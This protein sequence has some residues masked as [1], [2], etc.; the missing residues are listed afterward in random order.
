M[1]KTIKIKKGLNI[2]LLGGSE[3]IMKT[4]QRASFY[5]IKPTD[6]H[7][8]IP[9]MI[10]NEGEKVHA[11]S[12]LFFDKHNEN[13]KFTS[14]VSGVFQEVVRGAK[15]RILEVVVKPDESDTYIDYGA[16]KPSTL[17][18]EE[19]TDKLLASGCWPFIR[20][21][22]F[23]V[24]ANPK[25]EPR[26][27]FVS[28]FSSAPLAID[29][30]FVIDGNEAFFQA[31][32][33]VLAKLT[34]GKVHLGIDAEATRSKA[35]T[36]AKNVEIHKFSGPHPAGNVGIQIHHV[37][38]INKGEIVWYVDVQDI[39]IIGKFFQTGYFDANKVVAL[40][41]SEV[42]NPTYFRT[43]MGAQIGSITDGNLLDQEGIVRRIISG[44]VLTGT[45][46][47]HHGFLSFYDSQISVI[48]EGYEPQMFGWIAPNFHRFSIS[49]TFPSFLFPSKKYRHDTNIRS[50]ERAF[51]FTGI[52]EKV[53]PMD[54][55]PMQLLKAIMANDIDQMEQLGIYEIAPEDFALCEYVCPS[56]IDIQDWVRQGLDSI[57]AEFA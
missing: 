15:R 24:I 27:I 16:S 12:P 37:S 50:G 8:V 18:R 45:K 56:K 31:G 10:V 2:P 44:D 25:D 6:F 33:D 11:G 55:M 52:Y 54:V 26:D 29:L 19:I 3:K 42:K 17:S 46:V 4:A 43:K 40:S 13:I 30:D 53:L 57:R 21:R 22:P 39:V 20:Q 38:P 48:P 41:G 23:S 9:K 47:E 36:E 32:I 14:P 28:A 49:R 34:K 35:F 5:A 1:S 7:G 51:V